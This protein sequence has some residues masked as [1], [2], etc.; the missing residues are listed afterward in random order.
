MKC[1]DVVLLY[2]NPISTILSAVIIWAFVGYCIAEPVEGGKSLSLAKD[3][4]TDVWT[5]LYIGTQVRK[6]SLPP[7]FSKFLVKLLDEETSLEE[8]SFVSI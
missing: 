2:V 6:L 4:I 8:T 1:G 5:W 7:F 3:W